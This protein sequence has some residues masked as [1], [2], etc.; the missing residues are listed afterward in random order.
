MNKSEKFATQIG[1]KTLPVTIYLQLKNIC[2]S[3]QNQIETPRPH[4]RAI[5]KLRRCAAGMSSRRPGFHPGQLVR[6]LFRV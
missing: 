3:T 2:T 5:P 4:V 6:V 1:K